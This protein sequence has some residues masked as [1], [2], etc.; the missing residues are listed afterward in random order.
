MKIFD[1]R[2]LRVED[3]VETAAATIF[4]GGTV[5][6]PD[7]TGYVIGCD[8]MRP[9]ACALVYGAA[10]DGDAFAVVI[11]VASAVELLE[12]APDNALAAVAVKRLA[13]EPVTYV[14]RRPAFLRGVRPTGDSAAFRVPEDDVARRL[15]DRCGPLVTCSTQY[16]GNDD[17]E[18]LPDADL[19]I[20]RG[21]IAPRLEA[22]VVDLTGERARLVFEGTVPFDRLAARFGG[23]E[24]TIV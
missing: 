20:E 1:V 18:G 23:L 4:A 2:S 19:L 13:P 10:R 8:P 16:G 5:V 24:S 9:D 17:L 12:F 6:Y 15:L 14:V 7:E 22:S 11:C 21:K 3:V